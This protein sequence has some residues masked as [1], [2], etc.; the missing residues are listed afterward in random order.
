MVHNTN[1]MRRSVGLAACMALSLSIGA[2]AGC[3]SDAPPTTTTRT[4]TTDTTMPV[5]PMPQQQTTT[6]ERTTTTAQ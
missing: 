1:S 4:V 2:L 5:A 6:T 3:G